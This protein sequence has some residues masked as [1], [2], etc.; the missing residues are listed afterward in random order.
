MESNNIR[1]EIKELLLQEGNN[2]CFDCGILLSLY[3]D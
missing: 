3:N 2:K 1:K